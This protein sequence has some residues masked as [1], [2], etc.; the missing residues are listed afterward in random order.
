[1]T[2]D[3][4]RP[5]LATS[6]ARRPTG[7]SCCKLCVVVVVMFGVRLR[8]G[9]VLRQ[10]L[11]GDRA[12]RHRAAPTRSRTRRSTRRA[13]CG[14]SSTPT[15]ASCRGVPA[16]R[17]RC[18]NVHPGEVRQ[19][20]VRGRRT[21]PIARS[22]AR[23]FP[24]YGPQRRRRNI[25]SK[26]ECFCFAKQTLQPRRDAPD[27]GRVRRRPDA[28]RGRR[29]DHAVVHVLRGRRRRT[30]PL[31]AAAGADDP[32]QPFV[33]ELLE[34]SDTRQPQSR[35]TSFRSRRTGRSPAR[36]RCCS[37]DGRGLLVQRLCGGPVDRAGR[38]LRAARDDVRLVRHRDRRIRGTSSTT[39]K[40]DLSFRWSM[41]W[42]IFS[43]V[44]FFA[45]FFGALFYIRNL[46]VPD[47]G[48]LEI[49]AALA[50]LHV[51][52]GRPTAR[53]SR[54]RSRRW[55]RSAFR[56]STRSS[57][58]R[59]ASR[60]RS[61]T[62]RS[63]PGHRGALKLWLFV[64]DRAGLHVPG[65]PGVRVHHAYSELNLKLSTGVYGSTFFMLTGFHGFHVTIGAIMLTVMLVR[66]IPR[67]LRRRSTTSRSRPRRGTGT[68][69]TSSGCCCSCSSTGSE[70][71]G[72]DS[73]SAGRAAR[74]RAAFRSYVG[75]R[76]PV[77]RSSPSGRR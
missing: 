76:R 32:R 60:S 4:R 36:A 13:P 53:T 41:S 7:R 14:S 61:R 42:F 39:S 73:T 8:A 1:M 54:T 72:A 46:S 69:S 57:C 16:A 18:V 20:D 48:S 50:R 2:S 59:R 64:D 40:V 34:M 67:P 45:A 19:V 6:R 9:P 15:C 31:A 65:L 21:R 56:C 51:R 52:R 75:Y 22:P 70:R 11:R 35:T 62:T 49:E 71:R 33:R 24:S 27:A 63:R 68:S 17:R 66:I 5:R 47:L 77:G 26:L 28:A 58:C 25:S 12:A 38:V 10:D 44:M 55:A 74:R 43:E 30:K 3:E 23:R 37:W 29:D